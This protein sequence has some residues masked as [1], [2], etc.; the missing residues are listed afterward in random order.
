MKNLWAKA[1]LNRG[2]KTG[3]GVGRHGES[4]RK[5]RG[6]NTGMNAFLGLILKDQQ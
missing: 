2:L 5:N 3:G 1:A 4:H 6:Q